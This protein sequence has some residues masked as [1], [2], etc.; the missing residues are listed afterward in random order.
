MGFAE[1]EPGQSAPG[2]NMVPPG[3]SDTPEKRRLLRLL[4]R[5]D[6][7]RIKALAPGRTSCAAAPPCP[8]EVCADY[9]SDID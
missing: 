3:L 2:A 8:N 6:S 7:P 9:V 1:V 5:L 4:A